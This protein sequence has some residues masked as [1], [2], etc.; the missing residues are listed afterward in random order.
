M[1]ELQWCYIAAADPSSNWHVWKKGNLLWSPSLYKTWI[2]P[3]MNYDEKRSQKKI[4]IMQSIL[5][6]TKKKTS[7]DIITKLYHFFDVLFLTFFWIS[8]FY[9]TFRK[10]EFIWWV[11]N[12]ILICLQTLI[13]FITF[14]NES[15]FCTIFCIIFCVKQNWLRQ[16]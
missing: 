9:A 4:C 3:V 7:V 11:Y 13:F 6:W 10:K 2:K 5:H 1:N 12:N 8:F 15:T 14:K 16:N